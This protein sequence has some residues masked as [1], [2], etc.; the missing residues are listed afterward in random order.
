MTEIFKPEQNFYFK[1]WHYTEKGV[2][3][4]L[5]RNAKCQGRYI[6]QKFKE[7]ITCI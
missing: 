7:Y 4:K 1:E 3:D 6:C 5:Q 2:C